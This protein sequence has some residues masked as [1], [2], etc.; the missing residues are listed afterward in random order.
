MIV[1]IP[2]RADDEARQKVTEA[3]RQQGVEK[4]YYILVT[5]DSDDVLYAEITYPKPVIPL[6]SK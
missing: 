1:H 6:D 2:N 3:L 5:N 4:D